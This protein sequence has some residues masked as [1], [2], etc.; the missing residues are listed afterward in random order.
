[1][2]RAVLADAPP[3]LTWPAWKPSQAVSS[4]AAARTDARTGAGRAAGTKDFSFASIAVARVASGLASGFRRRRRHQQLDAGAGE[5]G[6]AG[7]AARQGGEAAFL[8]DAIALPRARLGE[9]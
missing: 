7:L 2:R 4:R 8:E 5:V 1:M 3:A 9:L 6:F